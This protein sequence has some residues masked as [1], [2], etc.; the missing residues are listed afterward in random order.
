M[1]NPCRWRGLRPPRLFLREPLCTAAQKL[2]AVAAPGGALQESAR[3]SFDRRGG[4]VPNETFGA[5]VLAVE[6]SNRCFQC[7]AIRR[8]L[9]LRF[10]CLHL[11]LE[12]LA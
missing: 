4:I 11:S 10:Q 1:N 3:H 12:L 5:A 9:L 2:V 6:L 7:L 8:R